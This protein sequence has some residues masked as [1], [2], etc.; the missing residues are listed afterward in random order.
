M[1]QGALLVIQDHDQAD[2]CHA[3]KIRSRSRTTR[4]F[5]WPAQVSRGQQG[6]SGSVIAP[7]ILAQQFETVGTTGR[8][9]ESRIICGDSIQASAPIR[10][11][12]P[13][14]TQASLVELDRG[15]E[16]GQVGQSPLQAG[17][18]SATRAARGLIRTIP[19]AREYSECRLRWT[20]AVPPRI[21]FRRGGCA[22]D[23]VFG[24]Q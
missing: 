20:K 17:R 6:C 11:L 1:S 22:R 4:L 14:P 16:V 2:S 5:F 12:T 15:I 8:P 18:I 7:F 13:A 19:S 21:S 23:A 9:A 3:C 10:G 24:Q